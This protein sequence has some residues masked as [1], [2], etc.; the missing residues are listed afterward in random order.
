MV[1]TEHNE[2][3]LVERSSNLKRAETD[4]DQRFKILKENR[5]KT[6]NNSNGDRGGGGRGG[7]NRGRKRKADAGDGVAA[8]NDVANGERPAKRGRKEASPATV[9][10]AP[11]SNE[12][13][14]TVALLT[15]KAKK[16][17]KRGGERKRKRDPPA[18]KKKS[19][20]P[21]D[22]P[23]AVASPS[24]GADDVAAA[25]K[26]LSSSSNASKINRDP[27]KKKR[28]R[29]SSSKSDEKQK[30]R[31]SKMTEAA[32][33]PIQLPLADP[34]LK[35]LQYDYLDGSENESIMGE[36]DP[37]IAEN[38]PFVPLGATPTREEQEDS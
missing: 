2:E 4:R 22:G 6:K 1:C 35:I 18:E 24:V 17:E 7:G 27:S 34:S 21:R 33:E 15:T 29:S 11:E 16:V 25:D 14:T 26:V 32:S 5:E 12:I 8:G 20:T 3:E 37:T 19:A 28:H 23:S 13:A 38:I 31:K 9:G 30:R 10:S 36:T